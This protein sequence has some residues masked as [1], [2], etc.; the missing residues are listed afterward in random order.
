MFRIET[1]VSLTCR[2]AAGG[3]GMTEKGRKY[4][5]DYMAEALLQ[6]LK[7]KNVSKIT[8]RDICEKAGVGRATW[9]RHFAGK[10]EAVIYGIIRAWEKFAEEK[11]LAHPRTICVENSE[12]FVDFV[13]ESRHYMKILQEN[14]MGSTILEAF[15]TLTVRENSKDRRDLFWKQFMTYGIIGIVDAWRDSG[16]MI[17]KE[18]IVEYLKDFIRQSMSEQEA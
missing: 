10:R 17:P 3:K 15:L 2:K 16:Y 13:Y 11:K 14:D 9:F 6:M 18:E 1:I 12:S 4:L 8:I 5:K 7:E